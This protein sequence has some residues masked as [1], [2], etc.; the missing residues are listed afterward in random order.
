MSIS[1]RIEA[2]SINTQGNRLT[3][4][5]VRIPRMILAQL[6][7]HRVFSSS[8]NSSRAIP[9]KK[10]IDMV[11]SDPYVPEVFGSNK[12]GM[13]SGPPVSDQGAARDVWMQ[14][15]EF[16]VEKA[17]NLADFEVHKEWANRLLE[18]FMYINV[19]ITSTEWENFYNLRIHP[20][21]Q[22]PIH[23]LAVEIRRAIGKSDPLKRLKDNPWH[24]PFVREEDAV[25]VSRLNNP[26]ELL[27]KISAARAARTSYNNHD[28]SNPDIDR[29]LKLF[30][31]LAGSNPIHAS[32]LEHVA[33]ADF[34]TEG[35]DLA[36]RWT[37]PGQHRNF[38]GWRQ[39]RAIWE[40]KMKGST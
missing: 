16:A 22:G 4:V 10:M 34:L 26:E 2:D 6:N 19:V 33:H 30:D 29:D 8:S 21:A 39:F 11:E 17:R 32:P 35:S 15:M 37:H 1:A 13:Q 24:L 7:T 38:K 14:S 20:D 12:P 27:C 5:A 36:W 40:D 23:D 9:V 31:L 28:G 18:P 25:A 3:T